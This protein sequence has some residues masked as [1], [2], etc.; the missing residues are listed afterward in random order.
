MRKL[1][2]AVLALTVACTAAFAAG[3]ADLIDAVQSGNAAAAIKLL[4]QKVNGNGT[5]SDGTT[6]L[7][8]AAHNA[9]V[10]MVERLI[11]AGANVNAK[12]EF[13]TTPISEAVAAGNTAVL[14]KLLK[15]GA[16][17]NAPL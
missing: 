9:D 10:D 8:W 7:H 17:P 16:D 6:A 5:T 11:R 14:E 15:A 12:N 13:G 1:F 3:P 4:D 2:S